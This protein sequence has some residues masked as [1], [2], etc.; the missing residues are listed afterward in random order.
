[1]KNNPNGEVVQKVNDPCSGVMVSSRQ[2]R[3]VSFPPFDII[4]LL[5]RRKNK[6]RYIL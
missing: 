2:Y 4:T 1:M 6:R 3:I 5:C